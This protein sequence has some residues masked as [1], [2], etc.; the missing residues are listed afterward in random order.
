MVG[1]AVGEAGHTRIVVR[2][3][4]GLVDQEILD[5]DLSR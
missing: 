3:E 4:V 5:R 1:L 2:T